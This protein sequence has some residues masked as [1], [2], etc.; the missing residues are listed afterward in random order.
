MTEA[1]TFHAATYPTQSPPALSPTAQATAPDDT[2]YLSGAFPAQGQGIF[3]YATVKGD[4]RGVA[5]K[6]RRYRVAVEKG[7]GEDVAKFAAEVDQAL[8]DGRGWTGSRR[9]RFVQV[10]S[11]TVYDFTIFLATASTASRMCAGGYVDI[12]VDGKPY[13]SCRIPG[14]VIINLDRWR[15][16]VPHFVTARVPLSAYRLYVVNHEVGHELGHGHE[17]CPGRGRV[18]PAMMQQTLFLDGCTAN[19][20]PYVKGRRYTGP[21]A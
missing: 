5:G 6:L 20:W 1:G 2:Y 10:P 17:R 7:S 8:G 11:N 13:T 19:P 21:A 16:S 15:L 3:S 12:R 4:V 14:K 18:A 9:L